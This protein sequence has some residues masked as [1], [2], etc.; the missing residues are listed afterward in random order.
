MLVTI[1]GHRCIPAYGTLRNLPLRYLSRF[2]R[3]KRRRPGRPGIGLIFPRDT[4]AYTPFGVVR[5]YAAASA[6]VKYGLAT[7]GGF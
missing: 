5:R 7:G 3:V 1:D 6:T 4:S 2:S